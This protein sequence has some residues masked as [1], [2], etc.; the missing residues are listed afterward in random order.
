MR[1]TVVFDIY[2]LMIDA[3]TN[4]VVSVPDYKFLSGWIPGLLG[5]LCKATPIAPF[6]HPDEDR[7]N[8]EHVESAYF[9]ISPSIS[10][11]TLESLSRFMSIRLFVCEPQQD[12]FEKM[13][14][15]VQQAIVSRDNEFDEDVILAASSMSGF[16]WMALRDG[17]DG[18]AYYYL[19]ENE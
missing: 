9:R 8:K 19:F 17:D 12:F 11:I 15:V 6:L 1:A 10:A 2:S 18:D 14:S 13:P 5:E 16:K 3:G 4:L 7:S